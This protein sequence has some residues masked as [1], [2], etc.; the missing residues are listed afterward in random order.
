MTNGVG[1]PG[2]R[3]RGAD[4]ARVMDF[5]SADRLSIGMNLSQVQAAATQ[6]DAHLHVALAGGGDLYLA[7]TTVAEVEADNLI[8]RARGALGG[9]VACLK[10]ANAEIGGVGGAL[11]AARP[12]AAV[13]VS[14]V[15]VLM[16][17][18]GGRF[19]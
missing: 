18:A 2:G 17:V 16:S 12:C 19:R 5:E 15:V 3:S 6:L 14:K 10:G 7:Y 13:S 4:D 8:V 1:K 11:D 9:G